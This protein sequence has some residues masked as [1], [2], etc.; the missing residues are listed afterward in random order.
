MIS[1]D[2][3]KLYTTTDA[4]GNLVGISLWEIMKVLGYYKR[5]TNG[6][7]NL[8]MIIENANI[9][10]LS[11]MKPH[12]LAYDDS[13]GWALSLEDNSQNGGLENEISLEYHK[14]DGTYQMLHFD[15][16]DHAATSQMNTRKSYYANSAP[17]GAFIDD[18][19][20]DSGVGGTINPDR[21][22]IIKTNPITDGFGI[23]DFN[24][25]VERGDIGDIDLDNFS[26][27]FVIW[28][29][30][31]DVFYVCDGEWAQDG[32]GTIEHIIPKSAFDTVLLRGNNM[33][34]FFRLNNGNNLLPVKYNYLAPMQ[35]A[36][37]SY[38]D[39]CLYEI[40]TNLTEGT[41]LSTP[42]TSATAIVTLNV[43]PLIVSTARTMTYI[44]VASI[45]ITN[46]ESSVFSSDSLLMGLTITNTDGTKTTIYGTCQTSFSLEAKQTN[47]LENVKFL[48]D[49]ND[50]LNNFSTSS[51]KTAY[52]RFYTEGNDIFGTGNPYFGMGETQPIKV[53][54]FSFA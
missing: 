24:N 10:K 47:T 39:G 6:N 28:N 3:K 53:K 16:Y 11:R 37:V 48:F 13:Y 17:N 52:V 9:N 2:G 25:L 1:E 27:E 38:T 7:R 41:K 26:T 32:S 5:D 33:R 22:L 20:E 54:I 31:Y 15:G 40:E 42:Y 34:A 35:Y 43:N 14:Y 45:Q 21:F 46:K 51:A 50:F 29:P 36:I 49:R 44:T 12:A 23:A 4:D 8:G 19:T 30:R 18:N